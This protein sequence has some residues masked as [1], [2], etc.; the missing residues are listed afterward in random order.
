MIV[1]ALT[2]FNGERFLQDQIDSIRAQ[3][4]TDWKLLVSDDRSTDG[5][6]ELLHRL[7][8]QDRRIQVLPQPEKQL[9]VVSNFGRLAEHAQHCGAEYVAFCDQDD[10]WFSDKLEKQLDCMRSIESTHPAKQPVLIH[11]DS[12]VVDESPRTIR[13]EEHT[14]ELQSH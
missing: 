5:T 1:I 3:T 7:A 9:G 10:V 12:E 13:S 11:T 2:T 8:P 6:G 14:S 4:V